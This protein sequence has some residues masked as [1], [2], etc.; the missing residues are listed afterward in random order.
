[1]TK[2]YEKL[3]FH[4]IYGSFKKI[5]TSYFSSWFVPTKFGLLELKPKIPS[6]LALF[7]EP[8][9]PFR[10]CSQN[11]N[12]NFGTVP[13]WSIYHQLDIWSNTLINFEWNKEK[14]SQN[15]DKHSLQ[16]HKIHGR[17]RER[18]TDIAW[19]RER[20]IEGL[21]IYMTN[22]SLFN[23]LDLVQSIVICR[24]ARVVHLVEPDH[25]RVTGLRVLNPYPNKIIVNKNTRP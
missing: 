1:M 3:A 20:G 13:K 4:F 7:T 18:D 23:L 8:E 9:S 10:Y 17:E 19:E 14:K 16:E 24:Y 21:Q 5:S 6:V 11:R 2:Q 22:L 12:G 25:Y 15:D